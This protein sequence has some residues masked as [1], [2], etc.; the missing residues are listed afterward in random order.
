MQSSKTFRTTLI[1][2]GSMCGIPLPFD[3]KAVFGKMRVPVKVTLNRYTFQSTIA[4]MAVRVI[5][6]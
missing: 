6:S 2:N 5:P 4:S 1:R 3:P